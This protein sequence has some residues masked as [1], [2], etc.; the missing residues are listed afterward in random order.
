MFWWQGGLHIE[1]QSTEEHELLQRFTDML[2]AGKVVYVPP[3]GPVFHS[4]NKDAVLLTREN[5]PQ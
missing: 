3:P 1:P 4:D 5:A 2:K